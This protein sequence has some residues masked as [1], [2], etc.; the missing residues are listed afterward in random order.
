[1]LIINSP[2]NNAYFNIALEEYLLYKFPT[3]SIF[4][5]YVNAPSIIIGKFQNTLAEINLDYVK[6]KEIKVV[7]R[8]SG[9][10]AVYHDLG[11]LNFS[12]HTLLGEN[13]FMDFS[14]FTE[15]VVKVLNQLNIPAKL[16]GRNDLLVEGKKFSGNAKLAR[17]GK[18]IQHGTILFDSDMSILGDALKINP[19]KYKDKAVKSNRARVINLKEYLSDNITLEH[20]KQA[21]IS[22]MLLTNLS[23]SIYDLSSED[24]QGVEQL[25]VEKYSTWDW[26]F[27]FSPKYSFQNA[28]K[29]PAGFIEVHLDVVRGGTIEKVKIFGDFFASKP[30]EELEDLFVGKNHNEND[31]RSVLESVDVTE[32]FGKVTVDE[33]LSI[34]K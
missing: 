13:D 16:E 31:I 27:G 4:L 8:M 10:G 12:F 33:I 26:N 6:E 22:E 24:I 15:P 28:A 29:I 18:M 23:A 11:N 1:M 20:L 25:I 34:F 2:S 30:I 5:L 7:R 32:F 17:N 21:L 14:K 3:T 9:G 19:L